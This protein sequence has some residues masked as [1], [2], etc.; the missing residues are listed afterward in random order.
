MFA[1]QVVSSNDA[2]KKDPNSDLFSTVRAREVT[3]RKGLGHF[4]AKCVPGATVCVAYFG[5]SIT[6][7][8]GWKTFTFEWLKK[9]YPQ[10]KFELIDAAL[11]GTGSDYGAYRLDK[12]VLPKKPD[13]MFVE[14]S[15]ND[16]SKDCRRYIEGIVRNYYAALP[17]SDI[18]F[19]Y[20]I[21]KPTGPLLQKGF[22]SIGAARFEEIAEHYGI[23]SMSM[24]VKAA[25]MANRGELV[26]TKGERQIVALAGK[27]TEKDRPDD[28]KGP[29]VFLQDGAHPYRETGHRL[30]AEA[31][32]RGLTEIRKAG[33]KPVDH[34]KL[35][36]CARPD[37]LGTVRFYT[38]ETAVAAGLQL[39][40]D[41]WRNDLKIQTSWWKTPPSFYKFYKSCWRCGGDSE[42]RFR[43]KGASVLFAGVRGPGTGA[44]EIS[45]DGVTREDVFF[46]MYCAFWRLA[47][48]Q[49]VSDLDPKSVHEVVIRNR[50]GVCDRDKIMREKGRVKQ[51]EE[52]RADFEGP[53]E[54]MFCGMFV[55]GE[56]VK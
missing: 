48:Y 3:V 22:V 33:L 14:F 6:E 37:C 44:V 51:Y 49:L 26:W 20:V 21:G 23:P 53:E 8:N 39:V 29:I 47:P 9:E 2:A 36:E 43:F 15:L 31:V 1:A 5:G 56:I 54:L 12:D 55:E 45:V 24:G 19:T 18:V 50:P 52:H 25:E 7:A 35:P 41:S 16:G 11:G 10:T 38:P 42:I 46:D 13:L 32:E 30:Y 40:G 27:E 4:F 17:E 28:E 34:T